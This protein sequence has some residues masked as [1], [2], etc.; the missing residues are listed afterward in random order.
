MLFIFKKFEGITYYFRVDSEG[1][2]SLEMIFQ[3]TVNDTVF[4]CGKK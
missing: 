3:I 2:Y 1:K 4:N